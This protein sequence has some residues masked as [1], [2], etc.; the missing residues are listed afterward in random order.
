[1][2]ALTFTVSDGVLADSET[3]TLTVNGP[4][5][6]GVTELTG[7][8][9][10][11]NDFVL[12]RE[13][14]VVGATVSLLNT[15]VLTISDINGDFTLKSAPPASQIL[16]IETST[17][18]LAPDGSTYAGFREEIELIANVTNVVDR[19]FFLPRIDS[20]SLTTVDPNATTVVNNPTLGTTM[21]FPPNTAKNPDGTNFTGQIS[22][23]EVPEGLAP[24]SLPERLDPGLLVTI[25]PVGVTFATPVPLTLLNTDHLLPGSETDLWS[26]EPESGTFQVVGIGRVSADGTVIETVLG[27]VRAADWHFMLPPQ[28]REDGSGNNAANQDQSKCADC[29]TGSSTALSSG[30]LTVHHDLVSYRSMGQSRNLR[31]VYKSLNADPQP[32]IVSD[33]TVPVRAALPG[34]LSTQ[35]SVAG[36]D[37]AVR[38]FT[39][40]QGLNE[41]LDETIRQVVQFDASSYATGIY[42][43]RLTL[44]SHYRMSSV[45]ALQEGRVLVNNKIE[46]PYGAGWTIDGVDRLSFPTDGR[47]AVLDEGEG[48]IRVYPEVPFTVGSFDSARGG[49]GS[50]EFAEEL[51]S[52]RD[53]LT[54]N[55]AGMEISSFDSLT[56]QA[57]AEV[58]IL[59]LAAARTGFEGITP[60]SS[61]ERTELLNFVRKRRLC[62]SGD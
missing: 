27:G 36:I 37:Q 53:A 14:P 28:P 10:D 34:S 45:A 48:G 9:L 59:V 52:T 62:R 32:I 58:D 17:A 23:S 54:T 46:S 26:L 20:G 21:S 41:D 39:D 50:L 43:Y 15:G 4:P 18:N 5:A 30:N 25:Q 44:R 31:L 11:T 56:S 38:H 6:E 22:I 8:I 1:M 3:I 12:G 61:A 57:L 29:S 60:L 40:T 42:P 51:Q 24:A 35:L 16:D 7:R 13:T 2:L 33:T 47:T 49:I 19:P 55:F